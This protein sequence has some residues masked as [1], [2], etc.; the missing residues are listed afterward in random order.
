MTKHN[1]KL[2][3]NELENLPEAV[4]IEAREIANRFPRHVHSSYIFI[5]IDQGER[6]VSINS[7]TY[8][9]CAGEMCILPPGTS[10]SCESICKN[11]FGPHS[12]RALCVNPSYLQNL[13]EEISGKACSAPHFNPAI[14]YKGFGRTSFDE[15]FSLLKTTGT[16]L[17]KQTAL[18]NFLYHALEH[19][20]TTRIIPEAT[21]PQQEALIRVKEFIDTNFKDKITLNVL[22]ETA[23]LSQFHLQKLFVKKFG[24]SPQE[25]LTSCRIYEAK[26]RIQ[27]GETLI[28][29]A[30]NSGF[31]DQ[32]HF[33]RHFKKVIGISPGRFLRE[34]R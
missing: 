17:E 20:S 19:F 2:T 24:L 15:L 5:L 25:H 4:L 27:S 29:A 12:Y 16:S 32:S 21:G 31:S 10:H 34:N 30:L 3:F 14:A 1:E 6:K 22:A 33:S 23:C 7:Q 8:S 28:E 26:A 9:Y 18:N 11:G 13:A